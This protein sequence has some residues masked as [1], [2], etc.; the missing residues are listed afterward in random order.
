MK[1]KLINYL[2]EITPTTKMLVISHGLLLQALVCDGMLPSHKSKYGSG[3]KNAKEFENGLVEPL[4]ISEEGE[5]IR[6]N[7]MDTKLKQILRQSEKLRS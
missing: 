3:Y 4:Y 1:T 6:G 5:F 7:L 2:G